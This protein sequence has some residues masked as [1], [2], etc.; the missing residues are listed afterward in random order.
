MKCKKC[1]GT[2]QE[3]LFVGG[4]RLQYDI[5]DNCGGTGVKVR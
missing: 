3:K 2:G 1:N 4:I 5:C